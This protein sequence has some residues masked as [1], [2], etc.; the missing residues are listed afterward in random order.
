MKTI[1]I[2]GASSGI[3][4]STV[5]LF[6]KKAWNVVATMRD[7]SKAKEFNWPEN[8]LVLKLDVTNKKE[9]LNARKKAEEKFGNIDVL[10]N[11]AGYALIGAI[12]TCSE[13]QIRDQFETNFFGAVNV[14]K[15]FLPRMRERNSG[16]LINISSIAGKAVFPHYGYY[17]ATKCSIEAVSEALWYNLIHTSVRV[18][19][20]EPGT[21]QTQFYAKGMEI[22]EIKI[23]FY[24]KTAD[25]QLTGIKTEGRTDPKVIA[26]LIYKAATDN[27]RKLRYHAGQFSTSLLLLRKILPDSAFMWLVRKKFNI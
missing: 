2:T 16:T 15:E 5:E 19:I 11:N 23:P 20:I 14:I 22:G 26:E 18:K 6:A 27:S 3:G 7:P 10:V 17:C 24:E 9:I 25:K 1:L 21:I 4:K 13:K 8:V 12:E